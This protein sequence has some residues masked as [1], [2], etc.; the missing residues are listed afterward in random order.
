MMSCPFGIPRYS[1]SSAVPYIQKCVLCYD[2]IKSG[3]ISEP[4]CTSACPA[5]ATIYG[6]R[7]EL[8]KEA[9]KRIKENPERYVNKVFGEEEVGGTSVLY[10]SSINLDFLG[11]NKNLG[12]TALPEKTWGAL[13]IVPGLFSGVGI[14]MG[15]IWWIIER[16]MQMQKINNNQ[17]DESAENDDE[18]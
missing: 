12:E 2:N 11:M 13:K 17:V 4:A 7:K 1:W 15:G 10:I 16:R 8:L 3:K 5:E 14:V 6:E 9:H 18:K